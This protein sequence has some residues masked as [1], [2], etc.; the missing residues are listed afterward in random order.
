M[1]GPLISLRELAR[2]WDDRLL[3]GD[4]VQDLMLV[5]LDREDELTEERLMVFLPHRLVAL[6]EVVALL[7]L[8]ALQGLDQLHRVFSAAEPGL[9]DAELQE[10]HRLEVRLDIAVRQRTGRIDLLE[11]DNGLVE[12]LLMVRRV[13]RRGAHPPGNACSCPTPP[14]LPPRP[15][16]RR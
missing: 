10:I 1:S 3:F 16:H 6:R 13:Q 4:H 14:T 5:V 8:H 15:P 12:E 11:G 7:D 9:L 2:R